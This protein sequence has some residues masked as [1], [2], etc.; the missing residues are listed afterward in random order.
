LGDPDLRY[1]PIDGVAD[2]KQLDVF[3]FMEETQKAR[4]AEE[5]KKKAERR[6]QKIAERKKAAAAGGSALESKEKKRN[7]DDSDDE[8]EEDE[9]PPPP[10]PEMEESP[11]SSPDMGPLPPAVMPPNWSLTP[12]AAPVAAINAPAKTTI[13]V[14]TANNS[15]ASS[16]SVTPSTTPPV[17]APPSPQVGPLGSG[18]PTT[19]LSIA[20]NSANVVPPVGVDTPATAATND[21]TPPVPAPVNG[22]TAATPETPVDNP[23]V[24]L[25]IVEVK[26]DDAPSAA[27]SSVPDAPPAGDVPMV[28]YSLIPAFLRC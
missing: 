12:A 16:L 19:G 11:P 23:S 9:L 5:K 4:E 7:R 26:K 20:A 2:V 21:A 3:S 1:A 24:V 13:I 8:S 14:T 27:V 28:G 22:T 10:P 6:Q 25:P 15:N 17:S 18:Q